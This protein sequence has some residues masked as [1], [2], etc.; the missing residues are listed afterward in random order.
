MNLLALDRAVWNSNGVAASRKVTPETQLRRSPS[1]METDTI[2]VSAPQA[3]EIGE[4][5]WNDSNR[6]WPRLPDQLVG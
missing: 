5:H 3:I 1:I 2:P 6:F 4:Q